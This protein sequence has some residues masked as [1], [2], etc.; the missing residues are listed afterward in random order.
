MYLLPFTARLWTNSP[1]AVIA[2]PLPLRVRWGQHH[3]PRGYICA[4]GRLTIQWI[5]RPSRFFK[6]NIDKGVYL[7]D[8]ANIGFATDRLPPGEMHHVSLR[9]QI[10]NSVSMM[11]HMC[12]LRTV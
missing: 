4:Q 10:R 3:H 11:Y 6:F 7:L 8:R 2:L 5:F 12:T 9:A 1:G